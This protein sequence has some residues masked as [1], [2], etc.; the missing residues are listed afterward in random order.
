INFSYEH[1]VSIPC[2]PLVHGALRGYKEGDFRGNALWRREG[3]WGCGWAGGWG[4]RLFFPVL[5]AN[6][7][8]RPVGLR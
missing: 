7:G 3:V 1:P 2:T 8:C 5:R 6:G 4:A